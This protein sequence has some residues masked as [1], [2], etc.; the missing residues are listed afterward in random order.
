MAIRCWEMSATG[1]TSSE[2]GTFTHHVLWPSEIRFLRR[3]VQPLVGQ[4]VQPSRWRCTISSAVTSSEAGS[5]SAPASRVG[6]KYSPESSVKNSSAVGNPAAD[7][8]VR[9][10]RTAGVVGG[11]GGVLGVSG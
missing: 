11:V 3:Q 5:T 10:A 9:L 4:L 2:P 8:K 7:G 1:M 6:K